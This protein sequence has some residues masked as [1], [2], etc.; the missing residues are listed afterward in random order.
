VVTETNLIV[1]GRMVLQ[2]REM[3]AG[4]IFVLAPYEVADPTFLEDC[5]IV[6]VKV[7]G[8]AGNDKVVFTRQP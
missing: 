5:Q 4:D 8:D 7:P 1:S 6:C 2:G 3:R